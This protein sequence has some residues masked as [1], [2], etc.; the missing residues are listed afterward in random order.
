MTKVP[1]SLSLKI[2]PPFVVL[3]IIRMP[4]D[5]SSRLTSN[6]ISAAVE[7]PNGSIHHFNGLLEVIGWFLFFSLAAPIS[8]KRKRETT[9]AL[10]ILSVRRT[11]FYEDPFSVLQNGWIYSLKTFFGD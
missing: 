10:N 4:L 8:Q 6:R 5:R 3:I 11:F 2:K 7:K 1:R 9:I